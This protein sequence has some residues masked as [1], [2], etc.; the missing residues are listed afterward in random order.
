MDL[1]S[2]E[3]Y[4][5]GLKEGEVSTGTTIMAVAYDGGVIMGAD[6]RVSTGTYIANRVSDKVSHL[7]DKIF[8]CRS[9]S[10][11]DTQA[12]SDYVRHYLG[13]HAIEV[14]KPPLVKTAAN[15]ARICYTNKEQLLA[16][17]IVAGHDDADG[18][19]VYVIP[20]A[21]RARPLRFFSA[22]P[23]PTP[24][25]RRHVPQAASRTPRSTPRRMRIA[26]RLLGTR[27]LGMS[28]MSTNAAKPVLRGVVFDMDGTL[29]VP[30]LDFK[31]MYERCGVPMSEDILEAIAKM[32]P[33]DADAANAV[34]DEMEAEGRRTLRLMPGAAEVAAWLQA[35]DIPTAIVTRNT[36]ATVDHLHDALWAP[37]GLTPFSPAITRDDANVKP[38]PDRTLRVIGE[39][40]GAPAASLAMVGDSPSNDVVFGKRAGAYTAL[41]DT[42]RR[43]VEGKGDEGASVT[44]PLLAG[45]PKALLR[46]FA[47]AS[48]KAGPS[49][50]S[51]RL[52]GT[53]APPPQGDLA[54]LKAC[55]DV[56]RLTRPRT[57][58]SSGRQTR[59][60]P[61]A[62]RSSWPRASPRTRRASSRGR[63]SARAGAG[64]AA[65]RALLDAGA[66]PNLA[67]DKLQ[68]P[69]HF[70]AFKRN[71]ACVAALLDAGAST[72]IL[73]RKG[74]TP[75]QD[76]KD[77]AIIATILAAR[78]ARPHETC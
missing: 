77:A 57:R 66:D 65:L 56:R 47:V 30:N 70:A 32:P 13:S 23:T 33:A 42:G 11:A 40:W 68:S 60:T 74:R 59:A 36:R 4:G 61:T 46:D 15:L 3:F 25:R 19:S 50:S 73:D 22:T 51:R 44:I 14:G 29:T 5:G 27:L 52:P 64:N 48:D 55:A 41:V 20:P 2:Q 72:L 49:P 16:G 10:A 58:R 8:M 54:A 34:I 43:F 38:K 21:A 71:P 69:L 9:G 39:A 28:A 17:V 63:P 67:N 45:L 62:S 26:S 78:A 37:K 53:P 76:T 7:H 18:G 35:M 24:R 12:V 75:D 1:N 31:L 6:S